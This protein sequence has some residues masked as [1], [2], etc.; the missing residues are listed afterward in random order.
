MAQL[1]AQA[2]RYFGPGANII[3]E[4]DHVHVSIPGWNVPYH[5]RLGTIG[6][7]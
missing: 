4:G 7:R 6:R 2:R 5:G 3:N 1:A